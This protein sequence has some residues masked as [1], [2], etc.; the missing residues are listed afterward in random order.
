MANK[1]G[2]RFRNRRERVGTVSFFFFFFRFSP[3]SPCAKT[4]AERRVNRVKVIHGNFSE[5]ENVALLNV[6]STTHEISLE[7]QDSLFF[8]GTYRETHLA[9]SAAF[10]TVNIPAKQK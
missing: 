8:A 2:L 6:A 7:G 10:N 1:Y 5:S 9:K 3:P 4:I